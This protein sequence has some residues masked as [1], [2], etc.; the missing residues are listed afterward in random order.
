MPPDCERFCNEAPVSRRLADCAA[1]LK[2]RTLINLYNERLTWLDFAHQKL[3]AAVAAAYGW[4]AALS[5]EQILEKLLALNQAR[6]AEEATTTNA[7]PPKASRP[8]DEDEML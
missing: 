2:T 7:K 3:A 6:A 8:K 5:D 4:P 1:K